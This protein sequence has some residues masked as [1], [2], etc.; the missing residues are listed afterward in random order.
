MLLQQLNQSKENFIKFWGVGETYFCIKNLIIKSEE[1]TRDPIVTYLC[2]DSNAALSQHL[3]SPRHGGDGAIK[4]KKV[5]IQQGSLVNPVTMV[6]ECTGNLPLKWPRNTN[7]KESG[8]F[9]D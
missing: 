7:K 4:G 6:Q 2:L 9:H 8:I 5:E 3:Q 1:R